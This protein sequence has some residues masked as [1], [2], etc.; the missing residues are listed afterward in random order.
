MNLKNMIW[1]G[2][3]VRYKGKNAVVV[4][5]EAPDVFLNTGQ[6]TI[7]VHFEKVKKIDAVSLIDIRNN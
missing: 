3:V 2:E 1:Q 5:L 4:G 6:E 7:K